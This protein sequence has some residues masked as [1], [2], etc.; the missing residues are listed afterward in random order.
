MTLKK[1]IL[2][3]NITQPKKIKGQPKKP[4]IDY[5]LIMQAKII[6]DYKLPSNTDDNQTDSIGLAICGIDN[7]WDK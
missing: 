4:K 5:K 3:Q 1:H 2:N 6:N 7:I